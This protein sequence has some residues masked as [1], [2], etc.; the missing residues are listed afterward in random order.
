MSEDEISGTETK[1][2]LLFLYRENDYYSAAIPE[3][4]KILL[5]KGI[6]S[7][8]KNFGRDTKNDTILEKLQ[9]E[10]PQ[11]F[12]EPSSTLLISDHTCLTRIPRKYSGKFKSKLNLD[13][14]VHKTAVN[15]IL[16]EAKKHDAFSF[17]LDEMNEYGSAFIKLVKQALLY[18]TPTKVVL[19]DDKYFYE[20]APFNSIRPQLCDAKNV[21]LQQG[22]DNAPR[23]LSDWLMQAGIKP[24]SIK[25]S[26]ENHRRTCSNLEYNKIDSNREKYGRIDDINSPQEKVWVLSDRHG[27]AEH[28]DCSISSLVLRTLCLPLV[29]LAHSMNQ[30]GLLKMP[31]DVQG[32]SLANTILEEIKQYIHGAGGA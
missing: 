29:S 22:A 14:L 26:N 31:T 15:Y 21:A 6:S 17:G 9:Q 10:A 11:L 24:E 4:Q 18:E 32:Q 8:T 7:V 12:E 25:F 3:V 28:W 30:E 5:A 19:I 13:T 20:H 23:I 27:G 2:R 1:N 16:P